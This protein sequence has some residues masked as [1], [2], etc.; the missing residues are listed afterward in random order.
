MTKAPVPA[1]PLRVYVAAGAILLFGFFA[2][3]NVLGFISDYN[4]SFNDPYQIAAQENR[5]R[6]LKQALP[7]VPVFGYLSDAAPSDVKGQAMFFGAQYTLAP[8]VLVREEAVP[9]YEWEIANLTQP[10]AAAALGRMMGLRLVRDFG[11]GVV[12]YHKEAR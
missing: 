7:P 5:F 3:L 12:L 11:Q 1:Y 2:T 8:R 4:R 10:G 6:E 9:R